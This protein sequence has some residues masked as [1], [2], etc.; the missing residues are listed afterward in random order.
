[1]IEDASHFSSLS[2]EE[3]AS[4]PTT[5]ASVTMNAAIIAVS[6]MCRPL[7]F[8]SLG[9]RYT[10]L[11]ILVYKIKVQHQH[12]QVV[13]VSCDKN[14]AMQSQTRLK[15]S[16]YLNQEVVFGLFLSYFYYYHASQSSTLCIT[17]IGGTRLASAQRASK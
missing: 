15:K 6:I 13:N 2:R 3:Y 16:I 11:W 10:H 9:T 17:T 4:A 8:V 1:M 5:P 14:I 7:S 12:K